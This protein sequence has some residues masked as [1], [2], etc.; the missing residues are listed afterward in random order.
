MIALYTICGLIAVVIV[1]TIGNVIVQ[2]NLTH[3][4]D[5][6][7]DKV[8]ARDYRD[9]KGA[10]SIKEEDASPAKDD[11]DPKSWYDH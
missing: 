8:M 1:Q 6:L 10:E 9:Y 5:R 4:I 11:D 2:R 3:S 7:S